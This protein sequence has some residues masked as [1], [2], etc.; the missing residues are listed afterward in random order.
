MPVEL[1]FEEAKKN[2]QTIA[3]KSPIAVQLAKEAI[4]KCYDITIRWTNARAQ[5]FLY[6]IRYS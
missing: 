2:G 4:L 6:A 1:Y 3:K 5:E